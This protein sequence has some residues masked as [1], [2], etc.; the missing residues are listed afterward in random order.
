MNILD[1]TIGVVMGGR[2]S[3][4]E[5]SLRS[6]RR[7]LEALLSQN[8]KAVEVDI[9]EPRDLIACDLDVA[10]LTLHGGEGEDG[11]VQG[12]LEALE[13]PYTG[14]GILASALC[15]NKLLSKR[16]FCQAGVPTARFLELSRLEGIHGD[17]EDVRAQFGFP[18]FVKPI[19][20]GSSVGVQRIEDEKE[21]L[22]KIPALKERYGGLL[23]EEA[24]VGREL[25]IGM[26][27]SEILP[28]LEIRTPRLFYDYKAKYHSM[29]TQL[30]V[31]A[32]LA[33]RVDSA[34][35]RVAS[36]AFE[37]VGCRSL[38]RVDIM[39][40][41]A[42]IPWVLEVNTLP[43]LTSTSDLPAQ[44]KAAGYTFDELVLQIL[45]EAS[46]EGASRRFPLPGD[47]LEEEELASKSGKAAVLVS[48]P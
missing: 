2:S 23:V 37:A 10:F 28:P 41:S 6:G 24:I 18:V 7:V 13:I 9:R 27:G 32:P 3:E 8:L 33:P 45:S 30:I 17:L 38:G 42:G 46:L 1:K 16:V 21:F 5:V 4:R 25:T 22:R 12:L 29:E 34:A 47:S 26:L 36:R 40:D 35:R 11:T 44:A 20:Q 19:S 48:N 43:G 14:S 31:P 39:L 15:M